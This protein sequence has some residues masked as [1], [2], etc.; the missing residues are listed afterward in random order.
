MEKVPK[1]PKARIGR[2]FGFVTFETEEMQQRAISEM[3]CTMIYGRKIS[4]NAAIDHSI[5]NI[6]S[7]VGEGLQTKIVAIDGVQTDSMVDCSA[8]NPSKVGATDSMDV[9]TV[10]NEPADKRQAQTLADLA[11]DDLKLQLKYFFITKNPRE[12]DSTSAVRCLVC[13]QEGHMAGSCGTL[14]CTHCGLHKDHFSTQCPATQK[15]YRCRERGHKQEE[16]P[17][18]LGR[19]AANEL[20]CDSCQRKGHTE[21]K[22]ELLWRTSGRPWE[23]DMTKQGIRRSC[24]ECGSNRHLGNDCPTRKPGKPMG[25][26]T[27]SVGENKPGSNNSIDGTIIKGR[28][29]QTSVVAIDDSEDDQANFYR[30]RIPQPARS[31]KIHFASRNPNRHQGNSWAPNNE[32]QQDYRTEGNDPYRDSR[33]YDSH[34]YRPSER[35]R[36]RS[37]RARYPTQYAPRG[38]YDGSDDKQPPL[39]R[40]PPPGRAGKSGKGPRRKRNTYKPMPSAAKGAWSKHR[41]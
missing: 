13:M 16:C 8:S 35:R 22:C 34:A 25:S 39:S 31:G 17:Y 32:P 6:D 18:K 12:V 27:W 20:E 7:E 41:T 11:P 29:Q 21:A 1:G 30:P 3:D 37:P 5:K 40:G 10:D 19:L 36:S 33:D 2:G 4:V 23:S 15:C 38:G 26:S 24:Y 9:D 28:A 14:L